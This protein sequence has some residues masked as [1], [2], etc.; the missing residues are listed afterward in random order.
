MRQIIFTGIDTPDIC[1]NSYEAAR[2]DSGLTVD[3]IKCAIDNGGSVHHKNGCSYYV[4][5]GYDSDDVKLDPKT[6]KPASTLVK[7]IIDALATEN[8]ILYQK[9]EKLEKQVKVLG[10]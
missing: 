6:G 5:T 2:Y 1:Y 7:R 10:G 4:D 8:H 3:E 9:V